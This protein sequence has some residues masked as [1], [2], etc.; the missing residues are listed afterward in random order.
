MGERIGSRIFVGVV[1]ATV[2]AIGMTQPG[3]S[4]ESASQTAPE[5]A[6]T[7]CPAPPPAAATQGTA[8][9]RLWCVCWDPMN[10]EF[11]I[12]FAFLYP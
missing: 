12:R 7:A 10:F 11:M 3:A 5:A 1:L 9:P 2:A 8:E 4:A 6:P